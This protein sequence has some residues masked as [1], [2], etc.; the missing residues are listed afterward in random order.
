MTSEEIQEESLVVDQGEIKARLRWE[1]VQRVPI[2]F[3]NHIWVRLQD[4]QFHVTFGQAEL[5]FE[6]TFSE[7]TLE[8]LNEEGV[9]IR[10]VVRLAISPS[11]MEGM[12]E[13]LARVYQLWEDH[14]KEEES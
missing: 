9:P 4:D 5:P 13:V 7:E 8:K 6:Q 14:Q 1:G 12:I 2:L 10:P 3:A 11:K